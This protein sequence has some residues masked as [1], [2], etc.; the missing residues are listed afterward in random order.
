MSLFTKIFIS[1]KILSLKVKMNI[2]G[3]F[4]VFMFSLILFAIIL[5]Q[6]EKDKLA[7]RNGKL[8]AVV[9]SLVSLMDHYERSLRMNAWK[10]DP[11]MP[12]TIDEAKVRILKDVRRMRYDRSEYFFI[13]DG[14]GN[15]VMHPLK[16]ELEGKNLLSLED[17]SGGRP[18][19]DMVLESQRDGETFVSYLWQSKYSETV[20]EHQTTYAKYYWPWDWTICTAVYTQDIVDAVWDIRIISILSIIVTA[21]IAMV[22][23]IFLIHIN[24]SK[25]IKKLLSGINEIRIG[26]MDYQINVS[27]MDEIGFISEQFNQM[28]SNL[29]K[30]SESIAQSENKYR[31][32]TNLLPD[33]VYE[34]DPDRKITYL[35]KT[36][37]TLLG[38][39]DYD[40]TNGLFME[41][42]ISDEALQ[43]LDIM[44]LGN[45]ENGNKEM[46]GTHRV[47]LKN[48]G[49]IIGEN[50]AS[51]VL[52]DE[53]VKGIRGVIRDVTEKVKLQENLAQTQ[54]METIGTLAGGLAHDFNNALSGIMGSI[55][56]LK[57]MMK[58]EK[59]IDSVKLVEYI[60]LM[61]E[62][63]IRATDV[64]QQLLSLSR[65]Q[66]FSFAPVELNTTL[67]HVIKICSNS[68][69]KSVDIN[70]VYIDERAMTLADPTHMEQVL[71]NICINAN[72]AMTIMREKEEGIGGVL[73]VSIE[74]IVA[75]KHFCQMHPEAE[76]K[77]YWEITVSDT[78]VGMVPETVAKMFDPFFTMK[79]KGKGTG[80]GLVMV[81]NIIKQHH[82]FVDVYSEFGIGTSFHIFMPVL[83][84]KDYD[85]NGF[86]QESIPRGDGLILV[87]DDEFILLQIARSILEEC[88]YTV[89]TASDGIEGVEVFKERCSEIKA[90]VLDLVMPK[91]SGEK[92]Y[93]EIK[94]IDENVK[95]LLTSGFKQDQRV[96]IA[97]KM[98]IDGF[99]QKPF[100]L[101]GLAKALH[102]ILV[103]DLS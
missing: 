47:F 70:P 34:M 71:L 11:S 58:K 61:E 18:F 28:V 6:L 92:V 82:G 84:G 48:G 21:L 42:L 79:E 51:V 38:Y 81:Y 30:S 9:N 50:N 62:S 4:I 90:V 102:T 89:I 23:M 88:G 87:V 96:N 33:I 29:K 91:K 77:D 94:K 41:K 52:I 26:N 66:E 15:M 54:K 43:K 99:L 60:N 7:E 27:S 63:G 10:Q 22:M 13:L 64:V 56:L 86:V 55:S 57:H 83:H 25:P 103:K 76:E 5:P 67:E 35:N 14:S 3:I 85:E 39:S 40:I 31:N 32:L 69:D 20:L 1:L 46:F 2:I 98:G 19:R 101:M 68:F 75:G 74:K 95:V 53:E 97:L 59:N 45:S 17:P 44:F 80:L 37:K 49:H 93:S 65:K 8:Q 78:G 36:G 24:L 73:S 100:T 12:S 72:H 16:K